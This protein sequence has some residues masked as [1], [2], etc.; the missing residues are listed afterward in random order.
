MK[1]LTIILLCIPLILLSACVGDEENIEIDKERIDMQPETMKINQD[2]ELKIVPLYTQY[3]K[4]LEASLETNDP[5]Q[6]R[7][8]FREFVLDYIEE[9][10]EKEKFGT[11]DL[12]GNFLMKS[13]S[14][15]QEL[16]N[17]IDI[18]MGKHDEIE[19]T[20]I[21]TYLA[22]HKVLPKKKST[23]FLVPINSEFAFIGE[24]LGGVSGN[25]YKDSF[26]FYLNE[27]FDKNILAYA[28]AHEYHHLIL[29]DTPNFMISSVLNSVILEGKADAFAD[30]IVKG[31]SPPWHEPIDEK[32]KEHVASLVNNYETTFNDFIVGNEQKNLPRW[33]NYILGK[34]IL[35]HYL[36]SN[37]ELSIQDWTFKE[38]HEILEGYKYQEILQQ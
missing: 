11:A 13:T 9:I 18:L 19:E 14:Y 16:L 8:F 23:I 1:K 2:S 17:R 32:T 35:N 33:S 7:K 3:Q 27:D 30:R 20:I 38:D 4:Y 25:A 21:K 15:E 12:K 34:D 31:V 10:G 36:E 5:E 26:V 28:T 29:R 22:S 24:S 37:P 6:K